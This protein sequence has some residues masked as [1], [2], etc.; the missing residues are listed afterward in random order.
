MLPALMCLLLSQRG[1]IMCKQ[2]KHLQCLRVLGTL[3]SEA[4]RWPEVWLLFSPSQWQML[5]LCGMGTTWAADCW[6]FHQNH[7]GLWHCI[8]VFRV[9]ES[10]FGSRSEVKTKQN[11]TKNNKSSISYHV[12]CV[13]FSRGNVR[14]IS[15]KKSHILLNNILNCWISADHSHLC[16]AFP[17]WKARG[18]RD[19]TSDGLISLNMGIISEVNSLRIIVCFIVCPIS[20]SLIEEL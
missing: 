10:L 3:L 18:W 20:E 15:D 17:P 9:F 8:R 5:T 19:I 14:G 4:S 2:L 16:F 7:R 1:K 13:S 11:T 6:T 12:Q